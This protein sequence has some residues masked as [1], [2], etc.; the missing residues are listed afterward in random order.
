MSAS[1]TPG[2]RSAPLASPGAAEQAHSARL[3]ALIQIE[4][5]A[6]GS[7]PFWRFMELA[8]YAPGLGYYSAGKTKF[9][10]SGD[11]ITAPELGELF[12]RTVARATANV[13]SADSATHF[14]EV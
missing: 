13:L 3:M 1:Q 4:I 10:A 12:A 5:R 8:L 7:I 2:H 11:F 6:H 9:G 14:L